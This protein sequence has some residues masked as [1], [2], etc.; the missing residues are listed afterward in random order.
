MTT[1]NSAA[2]ALVAQPLLAVHRKPRHRSIHQPRPHRLPKPPTI[3]IPSEARNLLFPNHP[4]ATHSRTRSSPSAPTNTTGV[5]SAAPPTSP[6][7]PTTCSKK[8]KKSTTERYTCR[9]AYYH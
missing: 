4:Q 2:A 1:S 7:P 6:K 3:V 5:T 8:L 9:H